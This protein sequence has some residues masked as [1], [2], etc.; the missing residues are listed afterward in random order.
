VAVSTAPFSLT[1]GA[2]AASLHFSAAC[3]K[4]LHVL[5]RSLCEAES[6]TK[7]RQ[8]PSH[9]LRLISE[10]LPETHLGIPFRRDA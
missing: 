2:Q 10:H 5:G 8:T 1:W 9:L 7:E 4:G 6:V 3:R